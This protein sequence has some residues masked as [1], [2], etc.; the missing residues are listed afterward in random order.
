M[1]INIVL[2]SVVIVSFG[3]IAFILLRKLSKVKMLNVDTV[4]EEMTSRA[5]DRILVARLKRQ[6]NKGKA[7]VKKKA[8]PLVSKGVGFFKNTLKKIYELEEKYKKESA[9]K[10]LA[11]RK[12]KSQLKQMIDEANRLKDTEKFSE[13]EKKYIEIIIKTIPKPQIKVIKPI[14]KSIKAM[15]LF[16]FTLLSKYVPVS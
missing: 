12:L 13:A 10:P 2:I 6:S 4:P 7:I 3:I 9:G 5:K 8:V 16:D 15:I 1:I 11:G 14:I